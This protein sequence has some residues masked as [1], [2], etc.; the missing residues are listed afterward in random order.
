VPQRPR[1]VHNNYHAHVYFDAA[2]V[3]QAEALCLQA[4]QRFGVSVGRVHRKMVGP[5]P[6]WSCQL[7][8]GADQFDVFVSWLDEDRNGLD[9]LVHGLTGNDLADHTDHASWLGSSTPLKLDIFRKGNAA[10]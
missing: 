6:H 2:S 9:I 7:A 10:P 5:H 3:D 8:F 4:G 1:N